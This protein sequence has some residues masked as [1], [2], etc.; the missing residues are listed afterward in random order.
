MFSTAL[1]ILAIATGSI[2]SCTGIS[3]SRIISYSS[4]IFLELKYI[5]EIS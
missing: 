4:N 5:S 2:S 1:K 3:S